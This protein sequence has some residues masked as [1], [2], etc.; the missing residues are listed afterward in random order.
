MPALPVPH[1]SRK[2]IG[3]NDPEILLVLHGRELQ[4]GAGVPERCLSILAL[5]NGDESGNGEQKGSKVDSE[6]GYPHGTVS[7][8]ESTNGTYLISHKG[9]RLQTHLSRDFW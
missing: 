7:H 9:N 2:T 4:A 5:S 3:Q 8:L 6:K 1:G